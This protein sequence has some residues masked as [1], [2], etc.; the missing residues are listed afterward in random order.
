MSGL[1]KSLEID[2]IPYNRSLMPLRKSMEI[3]EKDDSS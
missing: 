1:L 3:R 2:L